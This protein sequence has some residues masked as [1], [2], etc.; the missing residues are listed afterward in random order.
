M[1]IALTMLVLLWPLTAQTPTAAPQNASRSSVSIQAKAPTVKLGSAISIKVTL[2]NISNSD[3][4]YNPGD[5]REDVNVWDE[6]RSPVKATPEGEV[7]KGLGDNHKTLPNGMYT[8][9]TRGNGSAKLLP[10]KPKESATRDITISDLFYFRSPGKYTVEVIREDFDSKA[11]VKS[12]TVTI[13]V[14]P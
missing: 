11:I 10:L 6:S 9:Q 5:F 7:F 2:T 3:I 4:V 8:Y 14:L 13:T 1:K 12:N